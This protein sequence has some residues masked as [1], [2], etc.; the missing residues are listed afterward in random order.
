[1]KKAIGD[2]VF[3]TGGSDKNAPCKPNT[4]HFLNPILPLIL[5][6]NEHH[7]ADIGMVS[8]AAVERL[9]MDLVCS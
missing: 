5:S 7:Y 6:L 8:P 3:L 4:P 1:M 2:G 9:F